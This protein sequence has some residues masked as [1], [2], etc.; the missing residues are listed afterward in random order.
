[1][2]IAAVA[3]ALVGLPLLA[4]DSRGRTEAP[5]EARR[6]KNPIAANPAILATAHQT[7]TRLCALC[8]G[9]DGKAMT[10]FAGSMRTR[11]TNLTTY[12][13]ES[14]TDGEIFWVVTNGLGEM[15]SFAEHVPESAR[16]ELA[17][18]IREL[19]ARQRAVEEA[20]LGRYTWKL[21]PGFPYPNV[22]PGN[23]MSEEKVELGRHLF[24][25]SRLSFN[26]TQS[27]ATCHRQDRAFSDGR[28]RAVGSTGQLHP[29]GSM[30]LLNVAY[31][32][33]LT[34]GNPNLR[35]LE[36]QALV[37]MFGDHPVELGMAGK[38]DLL[39]RRVRAEP[40]YHPLF[41]AAFPTE[42]DPYTVGNIT[43]AIAS[44]ERT[45]LSGDSPYDEYRR[46]DNPNAISDSAKRGEALFFSERLECFHCHG[47]FN[48]TGTIDYLGKGLAEVEFH[49]TGLYNLKGQYSYPQSNT[50]LFAS[51]GQEDDIGKFKAPS[52]RNAALTAP[53]M[54]DGS[55]NTLDQVVEHYRAGGRTIKTGPLA[56]IGF[57]NPNK[58]EF[59][60]SFELTPAEKADLL[61]F[62]RS[63][64]DPSIAT[65]PRWSDPW[66]PASF[67]KAA[68]PKYVLQGEIVKVYP[69][70]GTI[71]LFHNR[72]PGL[73]D[74][75]GRPSGREFIVA[76]KNE[77]NSL[78]A[79]MKV[80]ASVRKQGKDFVLEGIKRSPSKQRPSPK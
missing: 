19:R 43:K 77:L 13:M 69:E 17:L 64:T 33:V 54:H 14:M 72:V 27:C 23:R 1:M 47:G 7:F 29:R 24:Y 78:K 4:H 49:N 70:D 38:E 5:L 39:I 30:S 15:P 10:K 32:P 40:R 21:P 76:D 8:H 73:I 18:W 65:N 44:F 63:L 6:V 28:P 22:P 25:D 35:S 61:S 52:L 20:R 45:L 12:V 59:I 57:D 9:E 66:H 67:T 62:L 71:A 34:W 41:A 31:S 3:L 75:A 36:Q 68:P 2:K 11:P 26:Q 50:G 51:T 55:L 58:S 74:A 80:T 56:G 46:H 53:Y 79:G 60:K 42:A 48:F 37:P 16:W